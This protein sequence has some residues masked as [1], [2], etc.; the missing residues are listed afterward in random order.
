MYDDSYN[1]GPASMALAAPAMDNAVPSAYG[2]PANGA[3]PMDPYT[4]MPH[5]AADPL[6]DLSQLER[7]TVTYWTSKIRAA[8]VRWEPDFERMR[9]NM[10]FAASYQWQGQTEMD[11]KRYICNVVN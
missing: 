9:R 2:S 10:S 4:G 7:R 3:V 5:L 8:K 11:D 6:A 1:S